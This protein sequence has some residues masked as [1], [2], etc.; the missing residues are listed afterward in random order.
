VERSQSPIMVF[1][2]LFVLKLEACTG[3][4]GGRVGKTHNAAY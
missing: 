3:Q 1:L 2:R 4:T